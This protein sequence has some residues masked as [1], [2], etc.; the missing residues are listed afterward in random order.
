MTNQIPKVTKVI[1]KN[2]ISLDELRGIEDKANHRPIVG[3]RKAKINWRL[4]LS[5][6]CFLWI[7]ALFLP[8]PLDLLPVSVS[9][10]LATWCLF[11]VFRWTS[12][13]TND[14][15]STNVESIHPK[16]KP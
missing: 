1:M 16:S 4:F 3:P 2:N 5:L 6:G 7:P 15:S 11:D 10:M 9:L 14:I 8:S 13:R 12:W